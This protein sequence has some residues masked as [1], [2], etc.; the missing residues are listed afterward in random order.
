MKIYRSVRILLVCLGLVLTTSCVEYI[1]MSTDEG[2]DQVVVNCILEESNTQTLELFYMRGFNEVDYKGIDNAKVVI[3]TLNQYEDEAVEFH[4]DKG[5]KWSADFRPENGRIYKLSI[6]I[7]GRDEITAQT[8]MPADVQVYSHRKD[9]Y[10]AEGLGHWLCSFQIMRRDYST[11]GDHFFHLVTVSAC[12][13]IS[14]M[15]S[16]IIATDFQYADKFTQTGQ[17]ISDLEYY[18]PEN[19]ASLQA[20]DREMIG[21]I[22]KLKGDCP[23]YDKVVRINMPSDYDAGYTDE[24]LLSEKVMEYDSHSF[25]LFTTN[26]ESDFDGISGTGLYKICILSPEYDQY[27]RE[28]YERIVLNAGNILELYNDTDMYTNIN[29]GH[30]IFGAKIERLSRGLIAG[31]KDEWYRSN[32]W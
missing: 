18:S 20:F 25:L 21:A 9:W 27:Y 14:S 8:Q 10:Y 26:Y 4:H 28:F 5:I 29:G 19:M 24:Q 31:P 1:D 2:R 17:T 12:M 16:D 7:E 23:V 3:S 13:W 11:F 32:G 15:A 22:P 6:K 30:G